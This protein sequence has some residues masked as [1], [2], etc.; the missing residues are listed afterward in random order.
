MKSKSIG[1]RKPVMISSVATQESGV[2]QMRARLG[3]HGASE[4]LVQRLKLSEKAAT[5]RH[6]RIKPL[7]KLA[8]Y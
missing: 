4:V 1:E 7:H 5:E 8:Y 3:A 2:S 6:L